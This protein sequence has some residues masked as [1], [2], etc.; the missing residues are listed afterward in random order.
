MLVI[1]GRYEFVSFQWRFVQ[2]TC[3]IF[4]SAAVFKHKQSWREWLQVCGCHLNSMLHRS[5]GRSNVYYLLYIVCL[6]VCLSV[7][8]FVCVFVNLCS[9]YSCL[10]LPDITQIY[11]SRGQLPNMAFLRMCNENICNVALTCGRIAKIPLS[12]RKSGS[13]ITLGVGNR[14]L[15]AFYC[16]LS[17]A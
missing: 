5:T 15:L 9:L 11:F 7:S 10:Y 1:D 12:Y 13:G 16:S 6:S 8:L 2:F 14:P 4:I 3:C 17:I